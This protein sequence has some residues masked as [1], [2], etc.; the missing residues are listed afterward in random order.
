MYAVDVTGSFTITA[1]EDGRYTLSGTYDYGKGDWNSNYH[2]E[3]RDEGERM[4]WH[5]LDG[6][7]QVMD[8]QRIA[9]IPELY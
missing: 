2:V 9:D 1:E 5:S 6:T 7:H 3:L 4:Q 8:F